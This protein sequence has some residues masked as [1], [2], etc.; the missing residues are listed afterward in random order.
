[1]RIRISGI[2]SRADNPWRPPARE[3]RLSETGIDGRCNGQTA[4]DMIASEH[5]EVGCEMRHASGLVSVNARR[6]SSTETYGARR[7]RT[8][9]ELEGSILEAGGLMFTWHALRLAAI[10]RHRMWW[11]MF[12]DSDPE[13]WRVHMEIIRKVYGY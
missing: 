7:R 10:A 5:K 8:V 1:M 2:R 13:A 4:I 12:E 11:R 9:R 3:G 6:E